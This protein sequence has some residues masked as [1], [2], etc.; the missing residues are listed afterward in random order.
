MALN[1]QKKGLIAGAVVV[2]LVAAWWGAGSYASSKAEEELVS[3]LESIGQRKMVQWKSVSASPF[4]SATIDQVTIGPVGKPY[5]K[6][7]TLKISDFRNEHERQ[8]GDVE[9]KGLTGAN[10]L[11]PLGELDLIRRAGKTDLPPAT[12]KLRWDFKRSDDNARVHAVLEQPE[13]LNAELNLK[14][15]RMRDAVDVIGTLSSGESFVLMAMGM[16]GAGNALASLAAVQIKSGDLTIKDDGYVKR[17]IELYKRYNVPVVP[18]KGSANKQRDNNFETMVSDSK[19]QCIDR[20]WFEGFDDNKDACKALANFA[21]GEDKTAK[22]E[23]NPRKP[24]AVAEII[25][26]DWRNPNRVFGL[27]APTLAN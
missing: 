24:V 20:K 19:K 21:S 18:D 6:M 12:I 3:Y 4:G 25:G 16:G 8:S 27:F 1:T 5:V 7:D 9:M 10:G 2:G 15:E 22:L 23:L 26:A 11:S 13:A 17:S 14:L